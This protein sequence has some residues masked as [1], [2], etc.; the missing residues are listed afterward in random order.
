MDVRIVCKYKKNPTSRLEVCLNKLVSVVFQ[1]KMKTSQ[2]D[3]VRQ[4]TSCTQT[5]EKVAI[6]CLGLHDW[7]LDVA[8]DNYF[9]DPDRYNTDQSRPP[10]VDKRKLDGLWVRYKGIFI[11][12]LNYLLL[13]IIINPFNTFLL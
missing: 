7:K 8:V 1:H 12:F 9:H 10:V 2:K 11:F 3:K 4:F 5:S 13:F 6:I